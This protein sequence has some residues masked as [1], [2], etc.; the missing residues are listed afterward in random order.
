M[1]CNRYEWKEKIGIFSIPYEE[2]LK[3]EPDNLNFDSNSDVSDQ[4]EENL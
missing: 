4:L 1:K 3:N 2:P